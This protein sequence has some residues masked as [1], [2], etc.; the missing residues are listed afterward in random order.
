[1]EM[2]LDSSGHDRVETGART[3]F[4]VSTCCKHTEASAIVRLRALTSA[5]WS[6][7]SAVK[8]RPC[9]AAETALASALAMLR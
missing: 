2:Q 7:S 4:C 5:T 9:C 3:Q 6:D 1:M 8:G